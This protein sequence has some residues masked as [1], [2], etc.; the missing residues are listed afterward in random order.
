MIK[1]V[2]AGFLS[3][4]G[5]HSAR[6]RLSII[7][8]SINA[9]I[10]C[11]YESRVLLLR[12]VSLRMSFLSYYYYVYSAYASLTR[13][14]LNMADSL[15]LFVCRWIITLRYTYNAYRVSECVRAF[16]GTRACAHD[17][18]RNDITN[19]TREFIEFNE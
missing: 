11:I 13:L 15:R 17:I 5:R 16:F 12:I 4:E 19:L 14:R 1:I 8:Y 10:Y 6:V 9:A 7:D 18:T 3:Q 2:I